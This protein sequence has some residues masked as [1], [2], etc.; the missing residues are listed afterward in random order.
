MAL[1]IC[2]YYIF[3]QSINS[4]CIV[5]DAFVN[6]YVLT[7]YIIWNET[8]SHIF[9]LGSDS[10]INLSIELFFVNSI[11]W[12]LISRDSN[13]ILWSAYDILGPVLRTLFAFTYLILK[14]TCFLFMYYCYY[15]I[16]I[17]SPRIWNQMHFI[18]KFY[19]SGFCTYDVSGTLLSILHVFSVS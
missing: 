4:F 19:N 17:F 8:D 2:I 12:H 3:N 14:T 13:N 16:D 5:Y 7:N 15:L 6:N 10:I 9:S 18:A 11:I 1:Y